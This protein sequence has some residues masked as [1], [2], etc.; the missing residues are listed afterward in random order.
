MTDEI[1]NNPRY[2]PDPEICRTRYLGQALD[3]SECLV[4]NPDSCE[5]GARCDG[6]VVCRHPDGRRFEKGGVL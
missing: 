5:F 4:T 1:A 2:L 3:L 6:S